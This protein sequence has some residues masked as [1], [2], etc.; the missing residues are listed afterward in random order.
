MVMGVSGN[1]PPAY[2]K[3]D[4]VWSRSGSNLDK[5]AKE[6]DVASLR[7]AHIADFVTLGA[8][9]KPIIVGVFDR[10]VAQAGEVDVPDF[11]LIA[12]V[13]CSI[14]EGEKH[15]VTVALRDLDRTPIGEPHTIPLSFGTMG[16]G[17]PLSG[18]LIL[19]VAGLKL[20]ELGEY[21]FAVSVDNGEVGT[22]AISAVLGPAV[23]G[24]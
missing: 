18:M 12:S 16:P 17:N 8:N 3:C 4:L 11:H 14:A 21:E 10:I 2:P 15:K 20:P 22:I 6:E 13:F 9:G 23:P 19:R 5:Q 7:Y 24:G 1:R